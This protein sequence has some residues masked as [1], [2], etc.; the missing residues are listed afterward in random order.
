MRR[1][2]HSG[3][4]TRRFHD[5]AAAR[6]HRRATAL[7]IGLDDGGGRTADGSL[8]PVDFLEQPAP[9]ARDIFRAG[10]VS[11]STT[12][13]VVSIIKGYQKTLAELGLDP[14]GVTRAVAT[15]ILS[16]ARNHETV[17]NRIRIACGLRWAPSTMAR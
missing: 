9:L 14:H 16:E 6:P 10:S 2:P 3:L 5:A 4:K 7:H 12:E 15:N 17:M 1:S 8:V 11:L 13:R